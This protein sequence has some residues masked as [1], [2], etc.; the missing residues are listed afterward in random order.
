M[1]DEGLIGQKSNTEYLSTDTRAEPRQETMD[2]PRLVNPGSSDSSLISSLKHSVIDY[3]SKTHQ[4]WKDVAFYVHPIVYNTENQIA[5]GIFS[6]DAKQI[7]SDYWIRCYTRFDDFCKVY[8]E[9]KHGLNEKAFGENCLGMYPQVI[10][11][12]CCDSEGYVKWTLPG[13]IPYLL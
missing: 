8:C 13:V 10:S 2:Q 4:E 3:L 11:R 12:D 5:P 6:S 1:E 7:G 9:R